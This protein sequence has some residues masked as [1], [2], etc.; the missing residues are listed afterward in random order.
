VRRF[1]SNADNSGW[2]AKRDEAQDLSRQGKTEQADREYRTALRLAEAALGP[3]HED[4]LELL[5]LLDHLQYC[6]IG[7]WSRSVP[8]KTRLLERH[9]A[10]LGADHPD[11]AH[12]LLGLAQAH[13]LSAYQSSDERD[14]R[15]HVKHAA[16]YYRAVL[17]TLD[18]GTPTP[19]GMITPDVMRNL[20]ESGLARAAKDCL[21][22]QLRAKRRSISRPMAA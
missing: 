14:K 6:D 21:R 17:D 13:D 8:L 22:S 12:D 11:L 2:Q 4:V 18:R 15:A 16:Q 1:G 19:R 5:E 3:L 10:M 20:A 7:D 9:E